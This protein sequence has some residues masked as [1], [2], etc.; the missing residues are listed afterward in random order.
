MDEIFFG[1]FKEKGIDIVARMTTGGGKAW[2]E[3]AAFLKS[4]E[5]D[6]VVD[7]EVG[8]RI[9]KV[10]LIRRKFPRGAPKKGQTRD[11]MV[12]FTTLLDAKSFPTNT[13]SPCFKPSLLLPR[14]L[15]DRFLVGNFLTRSS[16]IT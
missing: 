14:F 6:A 4:G 8:D 5:E 15:I 13:S 2:K 3:V 16:E 7:M 1:K 9:E 11:H 10:R 12:I